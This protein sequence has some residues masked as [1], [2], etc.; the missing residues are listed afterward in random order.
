MS[1][2]YGFESHWKTFNEVDSNRELIR[3]SGWGGVNIVYFKRV[4]KCCTEPVINVAIGIAEVYVVI[5]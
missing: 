3:N 5:I 2:N 4:L 1:K